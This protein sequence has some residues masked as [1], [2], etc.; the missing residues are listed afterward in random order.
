MTVMN[1]YGRKARAK[2]RFW[3]P[4]LTL[5]LLLGLAQAIDS[6][7][8]TVTPTA[9][10]YG[11]QVV[12]QMRTE[13]ALAQQVGR[14]DSMDELVR[15]LLASIRALSHYDLDVEMPVVR[16]LPLTEMHLR[17]CGRPC[18]IRAAYE[19]GDGLY[20]DESMRPLSDQY[21]QSILFHELVHHVQEVATS[22]AGYDE[23]R[24]WRRREFEAYALQNQFLFALGSTSRVLYPGSVCA[25][26]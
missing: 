12:G 7:A 23:C 3:T 14:P 8:D 13:S 15:R 25:P 24:R 2:P 11:A 18:T 19:P 26:A 17:L 10:A 5:G 20:I 22:H 1:L 21:E 4:L 9:T 16:S 6:R